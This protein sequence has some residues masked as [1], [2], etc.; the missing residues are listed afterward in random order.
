MYIRDA[1]QFRN[2]PTQINSVWANV[3]D[4]VVVNIPKL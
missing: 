3:D 1:V 2:T 4:N